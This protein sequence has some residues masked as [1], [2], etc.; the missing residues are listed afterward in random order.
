MN[1]LVQAFISR[2]SRPQ[3]PPAT[4]SKQTLCAKV[5]KAAIVF[6]PS[7]H[8]MTAGGCTNANNWMYNPAKN[9]TDN[10]P[11]NLEFE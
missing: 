6:Q 3:E 5:F 9:I 2:N 7:N 10:Q 8:K 11:P 4:D 1:S